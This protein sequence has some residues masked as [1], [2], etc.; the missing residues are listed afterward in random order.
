MLATTVLDSDGDGVLDDL[1]DNNADGLADQV[2]TSMIPVDTDGDGVADFRDRDSDGDGVTDLTESGG[3]DTIDADGDGR[4]DDTT[5]NDG[6][7]LADSVDPDALPDSG[8]PLTPPDTDGDGMTDQID[9]DSDNDGI[10]DGDENGDF[11]NDGTND[12]LQSDGP[13]ETAVNGTGSTSVLLLVML[14]GV[15]ILR[16]RK[17]MRFALPVVAALLVVPVGPANADM[18]E[19]LPWH[20]GVGFGMSTVDPEGESNGWRTIDDSSNGFK[21]RFGYQLRPKW[22]AELSYVDAGE[23]EIGNLNPTITDIAEID[24]RIPAAFAAYMLR[25]P[26]STWNVH[27]KLGVSLIGNSSNDSRVRYDEQS[28]A[29]I[30]LG[31]VAQWNVTSRWFVALEHDQYDRD[32]SFTSLNLGMRFEF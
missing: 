19:E 18:G 24:Y 26:A 13:L 25:D 17:L 5:D 32:A 2:P 9:P 20:V 27:V 10:P 1:A 31:V 14:S 29:Q 22:Y 15:L 28:S 11:D 16:S 4:I 21:V 6:D 8:T 3:D 12:R 30:A 23:A 7:G